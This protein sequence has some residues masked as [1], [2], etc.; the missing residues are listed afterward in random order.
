[1]AS[2][3]GT[4]GALACGHPLMLKATRSRPIV[5]IFLIQPGKRLLCF[6]IRLRRNKFPAF[7]PRHSNEILLRRPHGLLRNA[8][9]IA[10]VRC[11]P[12]ADAGALALAQARTT[13]S[14]E[15]AGERPYLRPRFFPRSRPRHG[16]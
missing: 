15:A 4:A 3:G 10:T 12:W 5:P 8:T 14:G 9:P 16:P 13:K 6:T 7:L 2:V 1:M 11:E